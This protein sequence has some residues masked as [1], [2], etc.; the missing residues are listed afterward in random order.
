LYADETNILVVDKEEEALQ[1]K[2]TT[3]MRQLEVWLRK[4][5]LII[6]IDKTC[7]ISFHP[8]QKKPPHKTTRYI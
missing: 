8:Y 1:H 6:N 4:N 3:I 2:I 5:D 7:A